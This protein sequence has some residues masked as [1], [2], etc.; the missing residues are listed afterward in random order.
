L[1]EGELATSTLVFT[2]SDGSFEGDYSCTARYT[3][4]SVEVISSPATFSILPPPNI[5]LSSGPMLVSTGA[6]VTL[7][8]TS[9]NPG[10]VDVSWEGPVGDVSDQ[11]R[12]VIVGGEVTSTLTL[13]EVDAGDGGEYT[14]TAT[15]EAGED[16]ITEVLYVRPV[17]SPVSRTANNGGMVNFTCV[18]QDTPARDISWERMDGYGNF[19]PLNVSEET[20]VISV[21]FGSMGM[22]RCVVST[23]LF[24]EEALQSPSA[25]L[26]GK[27]LQ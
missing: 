4:C 17:V 2:V 7:I 22:Y 11:A 13:T 25:S 1:I 6:N 18:V 27:L 20:L 16:S 5:T 10:T 8:C 23:D 3:D 15:N 12:Q 24:E 21:E 19:M 26:T 14:C 9:T